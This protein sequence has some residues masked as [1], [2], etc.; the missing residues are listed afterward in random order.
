MIDVDCEAFANT[1][2]LDTDTLDRII[3]NKY[4]SDLFDISPLV[5]NV[6]TSGNLSIII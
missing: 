6:I 1:N 5:D 4:S 2:S 3:V